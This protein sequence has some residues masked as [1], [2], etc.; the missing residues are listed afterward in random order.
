MSLSISVQ[1][2]KRRNKAKRL[3]FIFVPRHYIKS[4]KKKK[5]HGDESC[6]CVSVGTL[7][8]VLLLSKRPRT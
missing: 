2:I 8:A 5:R 6:C 7:V 3:H 4:A 1:N